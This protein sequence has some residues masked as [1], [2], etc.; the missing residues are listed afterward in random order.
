[1]KNTLKH[2]VAVLPPLDL[3]LDGYRTY[4]IH[5]YYQSHHQYE[6]LALY[7]ART[8]LWQEFCMALWRDVIELNGWFRNILDDDQV[9]RLAKYNSGQKYQTKR[10]LGPFLETTQVF[11]ATVGHRGCLGTCKTVVLNDIRLHGGKI[12]LADHVWMKWNEKWDTLEP[13]YGG[14]QVLVVGKVKE[15]QRTDLTRDL[16][17]KATKIVKL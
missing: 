5:K 13:L 6:E 2:N 10:W 17:I 3:G 9:E 11:V 14:T 7:L 16:T 1:M 8:S 12:I 4:R 15:Y